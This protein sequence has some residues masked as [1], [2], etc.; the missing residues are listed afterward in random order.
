[1]KDKCSI[2][3]KDIL[4][5]PNGWAGGHNAEPLNNGRCC[6]ICN[7]VKVLPA[8]LHKWMGRRKGD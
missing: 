8:R 7:D 5:D 3:G 4:P 2:C 1:M 6:G